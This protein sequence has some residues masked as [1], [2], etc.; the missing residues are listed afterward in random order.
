[1]RRAFAVGRLGWTG[2]AN[3]GTVTDPLPP[4]KSTSEPTPTRPLP[5]VPE[6]P[7][8]ARSEPAR[9]EPGRATPVT[10]PL[11]RF[12]DDP[13]IAYPVTSPYPQPPYPAQ[14]P[15]GGYIPPMAPPTNG[16]AVASLV[17]SL[18]GLVLCPVSCGLVSLVGAILGHVARGQVRERREA[19]DGVALAGIIVG[20]VGFG[21]MFLVCAGYLLLVLGFGLF[22]A[23]VPDQ[24]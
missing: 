12:D 2:V 13:A 17:C 6:R 21:I 10:R 22:G 23:T 24:Q 1:M 18:L 14:W 11:T 15:Y 16:M 9:F 3:L 5:A 20:W 4:E 8:P 7:V 19:G